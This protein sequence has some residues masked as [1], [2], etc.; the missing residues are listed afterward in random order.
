MDK[1]PLVSIIT[2]THNRGTLIE[3]AI[4][5]VLGQTYKNIEYIIVDGASTDNT[6]D[7]V[8]SYAND[9]RLKYVYLDIDEGP[10]KCLYKGFELSIGDYI[11][12]LDD[13]DEYHLDKI[14]KEVSL[15]NKLD[16]SYGLVYCWMTYYNSKTK[17]VVYFH[18]PQL[19][20]FVGDDV[21]ER[22]KVS[23]TPTFLFRRNVFQEL[24]GWNENIGIVSDWELA[25]RCCQKWKVDYIPESLVNVYVNHSSAT[26]MS[27]FRYYSD[28]CEKEL[29]FAVHFLTEYKH[30]FDKY[31]Q[32][33]KLHLKNA[34]RFSYFLGYKKE[35]QEYYKK[36][37]SIDKSFKTQFLLPLIVFYRKHI[38]YRKL[39]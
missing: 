27:D 23:G 18:N 33:A 37:K 7:I 9:K 24:G 4:K 25:V 35:S 28:R 29:K 20:G 19:R 17:E 8:K 13:D 26:R 10:A 39:L 15:M 5:S 36:L 32:R 34:Y 6:K 22:P 2:T 31:P 38:T 3:R 11:A 1:Q 12:F 14:E 16:P 30:I 21:V